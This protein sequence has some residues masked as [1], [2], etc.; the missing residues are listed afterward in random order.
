MSIC[1]HNNPSGSYPRPGGYNAAWH[2]IELAD[3]RLGRDNF[4]GAQTAIYQASRILYEIK[5]GDED[6]YMA[7]TKTVYAMV[8]LRICSRFHDWK[9]NSKYEFLR[10]GYPLSNWNTG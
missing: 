1:F 4:E 3:E 5:G 6:Y 9:V 8:Y 7:V 10:A 2:Q